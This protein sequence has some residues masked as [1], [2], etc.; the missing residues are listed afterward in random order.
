MVRW[1]LTLA[2]RAM[3]G[4]TRAECASR[5]RASGKLCLGKV[6]RDSVGVG[7]CLGPMWPIWHMWVFFHPGRHVSPHM[8][9]NPHLG[10][11][12]CVGTPS[13]PWAKKDLHHAWCITV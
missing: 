7:G 9:W 4:R 5:L 3:G 1:E 6:E 11:T 12:K 8:P 10:P 13:L 2:L